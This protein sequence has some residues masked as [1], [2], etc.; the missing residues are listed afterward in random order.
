[1]TQIFDDAIDFG[2]RPGTSGAGLAGVDRRSQ[3][4]LLRE[5]LRLLLQLLDHRIDVALRLAEP[6]IESL[7][8]ALLEYLFAFRE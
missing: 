5:G 1:M 6:L 7:V 3:R 2:A 8:Q 4:G